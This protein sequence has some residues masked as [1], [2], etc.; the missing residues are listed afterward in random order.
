[1][2]TQ[3]RTQVSFSFPALFRGVG[4]S[5]TSSRRRRSS[6]CATGIMLIG[7]AMLTSTASAQT[8]PTTALS[9]RAPSGDLFAEYIAEAAQRFG[10]PASW[11]R[12]VMRAESDGN[13]REVS[14]KGAM[15][16][17]QIMPETWTELRSRYGFGADPFDAHD[18]ILAGAAYL[19]ELHDRYGAAGFLAAYNA[20]PARYE[21]HVATGRPLPDETR[22][23]MAL[24]GPTIAGDQ[25]DSAAIVTVAARSWT[26][27]P[28]FV[29]HAGSKGGSG[30]S[31]ARIRHGHTGIEGTPVV[32]A[33][34][35]CVRPDRR[36]DD[37]RTFGAVAVQCAEA[38]AA[39]IYGWRSL[40][41]TP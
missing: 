9:P 30:A 13:M 23:Y 40:G 10:V 26:D 12:A 22:A 32:G 14:P 36:T 8:A 15:G 17:M 41:A 27:A 7:I 33:D 28:L 34:L 11:I 29:E 38:G 18:N 31:G 5:K 4:R 16:L 2:T 39:A 37:H 25:V 21:D 1:M 35:A 19:R 24:L 3:Q 6:M 20:G